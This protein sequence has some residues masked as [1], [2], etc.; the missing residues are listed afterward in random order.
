M[1]NLFNNDS[2]RLKSNLTSSGNSHFTAGVSKGNTTTVNNYYN[3]SN[4]NIENSTTAEKIEEEFQGELKQPC[5]F[6]IEDSITA[7]KNKGLFQGVL[8]QLRNFITKDSI[9]AK[10][11]DEVFQGA[12]KQPIIA[13]EG[14]IIFKFIWKFLTIKDREELMNIYGSTTKNLQNKQE[15]VFLNSLYALRF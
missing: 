14:K 10:K 15:K 4:C 12:L 3:P 6:N 1:W 5:N 9:T 13:E 11:K 8:K 2:K 7:E